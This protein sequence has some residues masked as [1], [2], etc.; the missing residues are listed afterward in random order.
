M[1]FMTSAED[2]FDSKVVFLWGT[3]VAETGMAWPIICEAR[4]KGVKFVCI[5]PQYTKTAAGCDMWVPIRVGTDGALMLAM[6]NYIIDND[7]IDY[8]YLRNKSVAPLLIKEDGTYLRLSDLGMDPVDVVNPM[9]GE[10]APTD[11]EVVYDEKTGKFGSSF[12]VKDPVITGTFDANGVSVRTVY[13]AVVENIKPFTIEFAAEECG[14]PL[15]QVQSLCELYA[16]NK[17]AK[18]VT[19]VRLRTRRELLEALPGCP[20]PCIH[21]W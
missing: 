20:V 15:E 8:D 1:P 10:S 11:T 5:D 19:S 6:S 14:L 7:L 16:K 9:T 21:F 12:E 17:P 13:D 4:E 2:M 3:N 18:I